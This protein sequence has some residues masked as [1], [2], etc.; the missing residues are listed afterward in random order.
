MSISSSSLMAL[1]GRRGQAHRG[2]LPH[3]ACSPSPAAAIPMPVKRLGSSTTAM[4]TSARRRIRGRVAR[5][6]QPA[7]EVA[8]SNQYR[9]CSS[10]QPG[11]AKRSGAVTPRLGRTMICWRVCKC[12]VGGLE[13]CTV[14][15]SAEAHRVIN[16]PKA[17]TK[18]IAIARIDL[19]PFCAGRTARLTRRERS[20]HRTAGG[21]RAS[22]DRFSGRLWGRKR[23]SPLLI[24]WF[25][26]PGPQSLAAS[27]L[28]TSAASWLHARPRPPP[29]SPLQ[30][31]KA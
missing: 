26:R 13:R 10:V 16:R 18:R 3:R 27:R 30:T 29:R 22:W 31:R 7:Q 25:G 19:P 1:A 6:P 17:K 15:A 20:Q 11:T 5:Y 21:A 14:A 9:V 12:S 4:C 24:M 28:V 8:L 2:Y 23:N